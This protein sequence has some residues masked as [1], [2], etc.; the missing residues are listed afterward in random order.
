M[1]TVAI[2]T[3]LAVSLTGCSDDSSGMATS[4]TQPATTTTTQPATTTTTQPATTTTT[5]PATTTTTQPATD[6]STSSYGFFPD[7]LPG[8]KAWIEGAQ[9]HGSGC[10]PGGGWLPDGMWFGFIIGAT[11]HSVMFDLACFFTG[12]AAAL[13]SVADGEGVPPSDFYISNNSS[14][15]RTG[16]R[17]PTGTAYWLDVT[18]DLLP[19]AIAMI[20]WPSSVSA[21]YPLGVSWQECSAVPMGFC[22]AW[23]YI[24]DGIVT[25]LI[26]QYLP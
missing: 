14:N 26:E 5:Q 22:A 15:I 9:A 16:P 10:A 19:Q 18:N 3:F 4:S 1:K 20:D 24:N 6:F 7:P 21:P 25:E 23:L 17:S 13:A 11:N 12:D 2:L 8:S